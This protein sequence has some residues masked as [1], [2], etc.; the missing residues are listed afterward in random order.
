[1]AL[2]IKSV[3]MGGEGVKN[4][5]N[6]RDVFYGQPL[7][8]KCVSFIVLHTFF[9]KTSLTQPIQI[10][11]ICCPNQGDLDSLGP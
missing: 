2:V 6:L 1:M 11:I 4:C 3:T 8:G 9:H 10:D 5:L 7:C